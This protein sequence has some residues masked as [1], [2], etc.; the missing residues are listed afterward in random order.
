MGRIHGCADCA[1][2]GADHCGGISDTDGLGTNGTGRECGK[3]FVLDV[4][5]VS[6]VMPPTLGGA[7]ADRAT[8]GGTDFD[9]AV[10]NGSS[11]KGEREVDGDGVLEFRCS[12]GAFV[13]V[14]RKS[15]GDAGW[16][17]DVAEEDGAAFDVSDTDGFEEICG[18][19]IKS[20][21]V[22]VDGGFADDSKR[23]VVDDGLRLSDSANIA[24]GNQSPVRP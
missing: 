2:G 14:D 16:A 13:G 19:A 8:C 12:C 7:S 15:N 17:E 18:E 3:A 24:R 5:F 6:G 4:G 10:R 21:D 22:G 1:T 23:G 9:R 11:D 20:M